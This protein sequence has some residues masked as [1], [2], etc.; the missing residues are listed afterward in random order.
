MRATGQPVG[1]AACGLQTVPAF[2]S[3]PTTDIALTLMT[4]MA[5]VVV[6]ARSETITRHG[7]TCDG[8]QSLP[9]GRSVV[10]IV[11]LIVMVPPSAVAVSGPAVV[12][13]QCAAAP[14]SVFT[15]DDSKGRTEGVVT[16]LPQ[17]AAMSA[18]PSAIAT[19]VG[20]ALFMTPCSRIEIVL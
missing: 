15:S 5:K 14:C 10:L 7:S 20:V 2:A 16:W 4:G 17:N 12:V 18:W 11:P 6:C 9:A 13:V 1:G 19:G 8:W 3:G